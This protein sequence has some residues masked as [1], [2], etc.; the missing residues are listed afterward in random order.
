MNIKTT[1]KKVIESYK[2][3]N[4]DLEPNDCN[5]SVLYELFMNRDSKN[6]IVDSKYDNLLKDKENIIFPEISDNKL[7]VILY[8]DEYKGYKLIIEEKS[9]GVLNVV[10]VTEVDKKCID[11]ANDINCDI[12]D[13]I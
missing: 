6:L 2:I 12:L 10:S 3:E 5:E 13:Y 11:A 7:E 9:N 1:L 4:E 8:D